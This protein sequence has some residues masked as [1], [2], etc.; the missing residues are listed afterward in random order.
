MVS[1]IPVFLLPPTSVGEGLCALPLA[2]T[3]PR[4][5]CHSEHSLSV[6]LSEAK[7]LNPKRYVINAVP[8]TS[9][10]TS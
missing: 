3:K 7:N 2:G 4:L 6:I 9:S 8:Y 10:V 1:T 5:Y